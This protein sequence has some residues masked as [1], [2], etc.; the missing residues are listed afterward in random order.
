MNALN[1]Q[2][3]PPVKSPHVLFSFETWQEAQPHREPTDRLRRTLLDPRWIEENAKI[4]C[5]PLLEPLNEAYVMEGREAVVR[6]IEENGLGKLLQQA[7]G[8]L[9]IAFGETSLKMLRVVEDDEGVRALSCI[10]MVDGE[11]LK[12]RKALRSFDEDWWLSRGR[13]MGNK[14]N[15]DFELV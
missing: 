4:S 14:L 7:K 15:F 3:Q 11:M 9:N 2:E 10:V 8:P 12:A 1:Y 6:F 13:V 5:A